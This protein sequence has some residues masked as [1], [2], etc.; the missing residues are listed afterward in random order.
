[1]SPNSKVLLGTCNFYP[2]IRRLLDHLPRTPPDCQMQVLWYPVVLFVIRD[3]KSVTDC[4]QVYY[5]FGRWHWLRPDASGYH[6]DEKGAR[7][8]IQ[9]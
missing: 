5:V 2:I 7:P 6:R 1:M 8:S 4:T 3:V 9:N